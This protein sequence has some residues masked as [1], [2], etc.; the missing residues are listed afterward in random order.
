[1]EPVH[2]RIYIIDDDPQFGKS[3]KR[4][5]NCRGIQADYFAS[6]RS[7]LDAVPSGQKG[8]AIVDIHMPDCDGFELMDKMCELRYGMPVI[9]ITGQTQADSR[10]VALQRG[11]KGFL[12]KPFSEQS[13]LELI[14]EQ[15]NA[16]GTTDRE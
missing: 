10:D 11:A 1:M 8:I 13:L 3:L 15:S 4:L 6:A 5:L 7:F 12:Q 9:V 16:E 2:T 14:E